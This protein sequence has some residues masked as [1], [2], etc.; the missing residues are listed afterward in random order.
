MI[1]HRTWLADAV[2]EAPASPLAA[3]TPDIID[4]KTI[5]AHNMH[6]ER[7]SH[8]LSSLAAEETLRRSSNGWKA[9]TITPQT[10]QCVLNAHAGYTNVVVFPPATVAVPPGAALVVSDETPCPF[11]L[12][13][14][15]VVAVLELPELPGEWFIKSCLVFPHLLRHSRRN[16]LTDWRITDGRGVP[17]IP[18]TR[19]ARHHI[20]RAP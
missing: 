20:V 9:T 16:R 19:E 18:R 17:V 6:G 5:E 7:V 1:P 13:A 2:V 12:G 14:S 8:W 3:S 11:A 10:D 4:T 15:A